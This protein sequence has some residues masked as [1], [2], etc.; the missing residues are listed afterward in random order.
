MPAID[1]CEPQVI[2]AF[3]K[4]GWAVTH[5][6]FPIRVVGEQGVLADLRLQHK[7]NETAIIVVEVKCFSQRRSILDEFYHAVGQYLLYRSALDLKGID[8]PLYLSVPSAIYA[9]FFSRKTVQRVINSAKIK[10]IVVDI[11]REEILSWIG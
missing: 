2:R 1:Q 8:S 4:Q 3:Q 6:P 10:V 5:Q 9:S 11:E 7:T